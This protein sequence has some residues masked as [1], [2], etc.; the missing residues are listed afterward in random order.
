M[1]WLGTI[2]MALYVY[3]SVNVREWHI[4]PAKWEN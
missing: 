2:Q 4:E 3:V 1:E